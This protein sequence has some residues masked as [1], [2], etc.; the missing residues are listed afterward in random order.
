MRTSIGY[1]I[2]R[3]VLKLKGEKKSWSIDPVD[4]KK[5]RK[6]NITKPSR[7]LVNGAKLTSSI[8]L[9]SKVTVILPKK[10]KPSRLLIYVHGGAFIYGPFR[11]HWVALGKI[12]KQTESEAWLVDYPKAP[13]HRITSITENIYQVY[14]SAEEKYEPS[15]IILIGDSAGGNLILTLAQRLVKEGKPLPNRLI[16]MSPVI[17]AS[18]SNPKIL[19]VDPIDPVLSRLGIRSAKIMCAGDLD[20]KDPLISPIYGDVSGLPPIHVFLA[21]NDVLAP[22]LELFVDKV[23]QANGDIEMIVGHGMPHVWPIFPVMPEAKSALK[24]I[25]SIINTSV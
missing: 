17:D 5:K 16:A 25:I 12:S 15:Q 13:E 23:K 1:K 14:K 4:Y 22:D 21:T 24:Q 10:K 11:E 9:D 3:L 20:L 2:V 8:I 18:L 19:K 7:W 6:L